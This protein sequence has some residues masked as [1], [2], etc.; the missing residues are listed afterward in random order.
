MKITKNSYRGALLLALLFPAVVQAATS[1]AVLNRSRDGTIISISGTLPA[2]ILGGPALLETILT[3][4]APSLG[5]STQNMVPGSVVVGPSNS[6]HARY[7][8]TFPIR[9]LSAVALNARVYGGSLG[10]HLWFNREEFYLNRSTIPE[11]NLLNVALRISSKDAVAVA[12]KTAREISH[13]ANLIVGEAEPVIFSESFLVNSGGSI[14]DAE[15]AWRVPLMPADSSPTLGGGEYIVNEKGLLFRNPLERKEQDDAADCSD[16]PDTGR[17]YLNDCR[18]WQEPCDPGDPHDPNR[19]CFGRGW[20]NDLVGPN[21]Y[22]Q[23]LETDNLYN[24]LMSINSYLST[25][26]GLNGANNQ[27]GMGDGVNVA[28]GRTLGFVYLDSLPNLQGFCPNSWSWGYEVGFCNGTTLIDLVA[29]EVAHSVLYYSANH[30]MVLNGQSGSLAEDY[31]D[32][33]GEG[34]QAFHNGSTDWIAGAGYP[35]RWERPLNDPTSRLD[36]NIMIMP[37]LHYP[38]RF[39]SPNVYC[40]PY[41]QNG[42]H[43][44][45]TIPSYAAYLAA[46][47]GVFNNGCIISPIGI[48][49]VDKIWNEAASHLYLDRESFNQ[50]YFDLIQ[51]CHTLSYSTADCWNLTKALR[52][53]ELD[54]PGLCYG[55]T[56]VTPD[57]RDCIDTDGGINLTLRGTVTDRRLGRDFTDVCTNSGLTE[58]YCQNNSVQS[59]VRTCPSGCVA[60]ACRGAV[61]VLQPAL[62]AIAP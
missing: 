49:K 7:L 6:L 38:D 42:A 3:D 46:Q 57:C 47:G 18:C 39:Y 17:C 36:P 43:H 55:G 37:P 23:N 10:I 11:N 14:N 19:Y 27:G 32:V 15:A 54:Q 4:Y 50:A 52:A 62:K 29:H 59:I 8:Q 61:P 35:G 20:Q 45:S 21:P 53:V 44:N 12:L 22:Y 2:S 13:G 60:G 34:H 1:Q 41:D 16:H 40:G 33:I 51:A 24:Y 9:D 58:Y 28:L 26:F 30:G 48:N 25:E 5:V 56:E 31:C